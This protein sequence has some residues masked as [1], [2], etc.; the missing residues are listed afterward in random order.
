MN[1]MYDDPKHIYKKETKV[2]QFLIDYIWII[3]D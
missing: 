3:I 2:L 1:T